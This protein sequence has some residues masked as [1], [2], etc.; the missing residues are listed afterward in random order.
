M[1]ALNAAGVAFAILAVP[2]AATAQ[3]RLW[4]QTFPRR[5]EGARRRGREPL[6]HPEARLPVDE[7]WLKTLETTPLEKLAREHKV[8]APGVGLVKDGD[9]ELVSGQFVR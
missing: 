2:T 5:D 9:L 7:R 8:Y 4:M 3:T 6:L 1:T